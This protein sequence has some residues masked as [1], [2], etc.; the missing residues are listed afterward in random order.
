VNLKMGSSV[1]F[2]PIDNYNRILYLS[3]GLGLAEIEDP[4]EGVA[5]YSHSLLIDQHS[6]DTRVLQVSR[7]P[8]LQS[9]K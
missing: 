8:I 5:A 1:V 4:W 9:I 7:D 3:S 2:I 6:C